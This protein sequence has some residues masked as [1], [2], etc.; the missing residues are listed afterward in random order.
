MPKLQQAA[1][2]PKSVP[3]EYV[4]LALPTIAPKHC[5]NTSAKFPNPSEED[6]THEALFRGR[7]SV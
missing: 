4:C 7:D 2:L 5:I 3:Q 1:A 6:T